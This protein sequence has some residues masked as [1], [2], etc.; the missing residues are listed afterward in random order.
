MEPHEQDEMLETMSIICDSREQET[1]RAEKRYKDFGVPW[2]KRKLDYGDYCYNAVKPNGQFLFPE[3]EQIFPY[4]TVERKESLD[5]LASCFTHSRARFEREFK[6]AKEHNA[7]IF[8][9]IENATWENLLNG[10]YRSQFNSN[11]FL[12]SLCA[13]I[14]RYDL[15]LIFCKEESSGKII[16]ELLYRDLKERIARGE[17]D[18]CRG[19]QKESFNAGDSKQDE[20]IN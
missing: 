1:V 8:L 5:E 16:K 12:A 2:N 11:A 20:H 4:C 6:R 10:K 13:W 18:D 15:Q 14:V 7:R 17:F 19:D 9:L 3:N